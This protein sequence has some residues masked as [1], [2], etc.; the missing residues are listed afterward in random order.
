MKKIILII[1]LLAIVFIF[2]YSKT[3]NIF[4]YNTIG[5]IYPPIG[6]KRIDSDSY[7]EFLRSLTL[8]KRGNKIMLY[9]GGEAK[10]QRYNYAIIDIPLLSNEEMCADVCIRLRSEFLFKE[11]SYNEIHFKDV[12]GK[13]VYYNGNSRKDF[14]KYLKKLYG[15]VSTYSL[16]KLKSRNLKDIRPGDILV[17]TMYDRE[18][19][20]VGHAVMVVDVVQN[21]NGR[22]AIMLAEGNM[23]ARDMHIMRDPSSFSPWFKLSENNDDFIGTLKSM[24][25]NDEVKYFRE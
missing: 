2:Y 19:C 5:D 3:S 8:K 20:N 17:Y 23:P 12:N 7:S 13:E 14:E 1:L 16:S 21:D 6:Y 15:R 9:Q 10:S 22:K 11:K 25:N 4:N 18:N 24:Y